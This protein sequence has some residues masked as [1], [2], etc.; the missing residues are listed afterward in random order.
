MSRYSKQ[1]LE[2]A[3]AEA[4]YDPED[5]QKILDDI[6]PEL[7]W[8]QVHFVLDG[9]RH[10]ERVR[11]PAFD[12][13]EAEDKARSMYEYNSKLS[14]VQAFFSYWK[15]PDLPLP[16]PPFWPGAPLTQDQLR[17][18]LDFELTMRTAP[19]KLP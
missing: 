17:K 16:Q 7:A 18:R 1:W 10:A 9:V 4:G 12:A 11:V 2:C 5:A 19:W 15:L 8:V 3:L 14:E 6:R 13:E